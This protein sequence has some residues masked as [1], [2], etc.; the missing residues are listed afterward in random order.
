[1][2]RQPLQEACSEAKA[3]E[4]LIRNF[5]PRCTLV[6]AASV[7]KKLGASPDRLL[8][9]IE[10][11]I[12]FNERWGPNAFA[13]IGPKRL[14]RGIEI[15]ALDG[16][17][18]VRANTRLFVR[19]KHIVESL[20]RGVPVVFNCYRAPRGVWRHSVLAIGYQSQGKRILTLD[21]N[22]GVETWMSW[23]HPRTGWVCTATFIE[24]LD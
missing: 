1:M 4:W 15:A 7:L 10:K 19:W 5:G 24:P 22:D 17:I 9:L 21:P 16:G 23:L 6:C 3:P 13:Y 12:K 20:E 2:E 14:D 8:Q 18:K 11:T